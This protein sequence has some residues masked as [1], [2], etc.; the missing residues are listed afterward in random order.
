VDA[1]ESVGRIVLIAWGRTAWDAQQRLVGDTDVPL[2]DEGRVEAEQIARAVAGQAIV[3]VFCG[4]EDA[5]RQTADAIG[6]ATGRK[7]RVKEELHEIDLG[8]W[9]GLTE[10]EFRERFPSVYRQWKEDPTTVRPPE[11]ESLDEAAARLEAGLAKLLRRRRQTNVA[12]VTGPF[13]AATL[14][15]RL[16]SASLSRFWERVEERRSWIALPMPG[17]ARP[18]SPR[19]APSSER[20]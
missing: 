17:P 3:A 4:P 11:G 20:K 6:K 13:A 10:A 19:A 2:S 8:H 5:A 7:V 15:L 18:R 16:E 14:S 12:I 9:E 1:A